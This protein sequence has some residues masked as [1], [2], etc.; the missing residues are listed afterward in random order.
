VRGWEKHLA[1]AAVA[2]V[3]LLAVLYLGDWLVLRH[4]VAIG[5]GYSVVEVDQFLATPLKGDKT[6]Y[7]LTGTQQVKCVS[8]IFPHQTYPACWWV[9]RNR[10][11]WQ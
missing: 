5:S 1:R 8:S 7:D 4:R 3:V 9:K 6:E 11:Q 10:S 2:L